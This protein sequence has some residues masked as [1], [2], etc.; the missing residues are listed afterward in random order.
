MD[1][2]VSPR[3]EGVEKL[4]DP[5]ALVS[6]DD[7]KVRRACAPCGHDHPLDKRKAE[8]GY[9]GFGAAPLRDPAAGTGGDDQA[10]R[11]HDSRAPRINSSVR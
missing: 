1:R 3:G 11:R 4:T 5:V 7:V 6:G 9:E 10:R 2:Y 8:E